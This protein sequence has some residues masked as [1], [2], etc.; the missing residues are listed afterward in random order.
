MGSRLEGQQVRP[1]PIP[2][3]REGFQGVPGHPGEP[4]RLAR[5]PEHPDSWAELTF[6][7]THD[8]FH[9]KTVLITGASS[10]MGESLAMQL[11]DAGAQL[12]LSASCLASASPI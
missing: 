5:A 12:T 11:P 10:G 1:G 2:E 9:G 8:F 7:L 4:S 3:F 6:T